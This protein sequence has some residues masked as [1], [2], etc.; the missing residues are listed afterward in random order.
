MI[1][2][3]SVD[4]RQCLSAGK[5]SW[6][7]TWSV[8][9]ADASIEFVPMFWG[10]K[11]IGQWTS[12]IQKT[13]SNS[14]LNITTAL[15]M[16]EPEHS[17]Q[18]NLTAQE[19]VDLWKTYVEP[20]HAMGYRLGSPA[21][22]S[23]P[24]GKVWLRDFLTACGGNCTVDFIALHWYGTNASWFITYVEDFHNTFQKPI[25]VT[26]WACMN[27][28]DLTKQC[29]ADETAAFLNI[30]QSFLDEADFVE[31]YSWFGAMKVVDAVNPNIATMDHN[32]NINAL[33]SQYIGSSGSRVTGNPSSALIQGFP[34]SALLFFTGLSGLYSLLFLL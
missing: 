24:S 10:E 20:L 11:A 22:S 15:G 32:G 27:F 30:T 6:Y 34:F 33:G 7:Y 1:F 26:E 5:V 29:S 4:I 25:W 12:M 13:F 8:F 19:G 23:A 14:K 3:N 28:V 18:S 16:N 9:P 17:G 2:R 21:T 31:R